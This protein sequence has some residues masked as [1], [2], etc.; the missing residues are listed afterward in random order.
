MEYATFK[1]LLKFTNS[2]VHISDYTEITQ[3]YKFLH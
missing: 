3:K 1:K 2:F